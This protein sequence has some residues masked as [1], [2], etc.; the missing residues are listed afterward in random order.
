MKTNVLLAFVV[1]GAM[2]LTSCSNKIDEKTMGEI[3]QFGS[4]WTALGE[5]ATAWSGELT[6]TTQQSTELAAK[7]KTMM[8]TMATSKDETMKAKAAEMSRIADEDAAKMNNMM[9]EWTSF[10]TSY[11]ENTKA[12]TE[13][14]DKITKGEV[15]PPDAV[16]GLTDWKSKMADA[17]GRI[18]TWSTDLAAAKEN[19]S[20]NMAMA[21]E[22]EKPAMEAQK[23]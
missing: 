6:A 7:Q 4:D 3:N 17:Q 10:K 23:K 2:G 19:V 12:F 20:K 21:A 1:A 16:K 14:K 18:D 9:T 5:K 15:S 13:W 11:D 22:M 8:E